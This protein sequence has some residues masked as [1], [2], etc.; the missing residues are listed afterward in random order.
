MVNRFVLPDDCKNAIFLADR[1]FASLNVV[2][3]LLFSGYFFLIR[4]SDGKIP[5]FINECTDDNREYNKHVEVILTRNRKRKNLNPTKADNYRILKPTATFDYLPKDSDAEVTLKYRVV[6]F[7]LDNGTYET[8]ITNLPDSY[9]F[10]ELKKLYRLRW[11]EETA[12]RRLKHTLGGTCFISK[13]IKLVTQEIWARMILF[14]FCMEIASHIK[15]RRKDRKYKYQI[16]YDD[17]IKY[18]HFFIRN[19]TNASETE[20]LIRSSILPIRPDRVFP[21]RKAVVIPLKFAYRR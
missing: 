9:S 21:R 13:S 18:C 5:G 16:N 20:S 14:N 2:A 15:V 6:K 3:H 4:L 7:L 1:G 17:A 19:I 10:N 11:G 8:V 12:F